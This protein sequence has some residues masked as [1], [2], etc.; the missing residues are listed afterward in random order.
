MFGF[1]AF[2]SP[3]GVDEFPHLTAEQLHAALA[4]I[5][6]FDGLLIVHAEDPARLRD[7]LVDGRDYAAFVASRPDEAETSA[8]ETIIAAVRATGGRAHVLHL[9]SAQALPAIRAAKAEGLPIT[10]ETCRIT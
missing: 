3:S 8:I 7:E 5:A 10:V 4:E 6:E 1:K 9:S 2:L